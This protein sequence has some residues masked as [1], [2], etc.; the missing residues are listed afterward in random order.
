VQVGVT[1]LG[2]DS[3]VEFCA[4]FTSIPVEAAWMADAIRRLRTG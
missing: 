1:S 4:G 3:R 2:A